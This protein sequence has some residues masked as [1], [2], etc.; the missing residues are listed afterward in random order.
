MTERLLPK[1]NSVE[2]VRLSHDDPHSFAEKSGGYIVLED[3]AEENEAYEIYY[4][5]LN[6]DKES[7]DSAK[8]VFKRIKWGSGSLRID[9][10]A[11]LYVRHDKDLRV[12]DV[13]FPVQIRLYIK[14]NEEYDTF[15]IMPKKA[16]NRGKI[17]LIILSKE[18]GIRCMEEAPI[19]KKN[20]EIE[21][22]EDLPKDLKKELISA[23]HAPL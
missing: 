20:W 19:D 2:K 10:D 15:F 5:F 1:S 18:T 21:G 17:S 9:T 7:V 8:L 11:K 22:L 14:E 13:G 12:F 23:R 16:Q 4:K 6:A 3:R